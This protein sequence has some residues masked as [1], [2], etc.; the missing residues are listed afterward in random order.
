MHCARDQH[1]RRQAPAGKHTGG[2]QE[3]PTVPPG[4]LHQS[5]NNGDPRIGQIKTHVLNEFN[6]SDSHRKGGGRNKGACRELQAGLGPG[7]A[8]Q[9]R[10]FSALTAASSCDRAIGTRWAELQ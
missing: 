1:A 5:F 8:T 4:S 6:G 3:S 10:L 2:A 7:I 9:P